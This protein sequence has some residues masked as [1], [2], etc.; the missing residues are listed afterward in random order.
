MA[1]TRQTLSTG[2]KPSGWR[3]KLDRYFPQCAEARC[4]GRGNRLPLPRRRASGVYLSRSWYCSAKCLLPALERSF[5]DLLVE[6]ETRPARAHRV[7]L[8]LL[9]LERGVIRPDQLRQ[10]LALQKERGEGRVGDWLRRI[11]AASEDDVTR[12]LATQWACPVFPLERDQGYRQCAGLVPLHVC[13]AYRLLPVFLSRDRSLLYV[14]FTTGVDH[15]L[16]YGIERM[17]GCRTVPSIVSESSYAAAMADLE[18][19]AEPQETIFDS[20]RGAFEIAHAA[21]AFTERLQAEALHLAR[22]GRTLWVRFLC[23]SG[24]RDLLFQLPAR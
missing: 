14:A 24:P 12:A 1:S 22:V 11:G 23:P 20:V 4:Q 15:A 10:A 2:A 17:L 7:P 6:P 16:L 3:E 19:R 18:G 13:S 8:G 5:G 21:C 9:L